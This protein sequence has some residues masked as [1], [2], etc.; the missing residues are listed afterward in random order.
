MVTIHTVPERQSSLPSES[1]FSA[2]G[3]P[4]ADHALFLLQGKPLATPYAR[5]IMA[6]LPQTHWRGGTATLIDQVAV[7]RHESINDLP[8]H[9][10]TTP[11]IFHPVSESRVFTRVDAGKVFDDDLLPA[12][13]RIP[14]PELVEL[15]RNN[16]MG[17]RKEERA[18]MFWDRMRDEEEKRAAQVKRREEAER[19]RTTLVVQPGGRAD[20]R[21][22]DVRVDV[23]TVGPTGRG[24]QGVGARYG[25]PHEDR[26]KGQIKIPTRVA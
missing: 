2:P 23:T 10:A 12:D 4:R 14:H 8:V 21:F 13:E 7:T 24:P 17:M 6:M 5:A 3:C 9:K 19:K 1:P 16:L 15:E 25:F 20:Y 26:K 11:Q 22:Q 18:K